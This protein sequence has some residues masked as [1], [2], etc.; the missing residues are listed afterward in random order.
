[1]I[2]VFTKFPIKREFL[3]VFKER[4]VASFGQKG[5]R[6]Q[7]GFVSMKLLS[8]KDYPN[9]PENNQF[10]IETIWQDSNYF[11][12]YTKSDAYKEAHKDGPPREWFAGQP[13][14]EVFEIAKE[15]V[16]E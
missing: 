2:A 15:I 3:Q 10:V 13:T 6:K 5:L 9:M 14:V 1:M 11:K 8:A 7:E 16:P 4:A 12:D